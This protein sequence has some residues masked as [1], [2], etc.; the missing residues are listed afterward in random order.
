MMELLNE[1]MENF[2]YFTWIVNSIS[3]P[4]KFDLKQ[5]EHS[6]RQCI[7]MIAHSFDI[8][9]NHFEFFENDTYTTYM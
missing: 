3:Y 5:C 8:E 9:I 2:N 1:T 6:I 4:S 7:E